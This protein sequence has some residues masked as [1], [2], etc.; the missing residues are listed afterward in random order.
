MIEVV[1]SANMALYQAEIDDMFKM[2]YRTAV[3]ELGWKLPDAHNGYDIDSYDSESTVY[4][5]KLDEDRSVRA[6]ARLNPTF[7]ATLM[8]DIFPDFCEFDTLPKAHDTY[9][10]TRYLVEKRGATRSEFLEGRAHIIVAINEYCIANDIN[11]ISWLTY[12]QNYPEACLLWET[13]PLGPAK[14][15]ADDGAEYIAARSHMNEEGLARCRKWAKAK[16]QIA[17]MIVPLNYAP[18]QFEPSKAA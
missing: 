4:F 10:L 11:I 2:R 6:C 14:Y 3:D 7:G 15:V 8:E 16:R 17:N 9:E 12:K 1:T 13:E 18:P 5:L